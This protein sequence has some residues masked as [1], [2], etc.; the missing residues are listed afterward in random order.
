MAW[1]ETERQSLVATLRST[2]P[3]APTLCTGWDTRHVLAHLVQREHSPASSVGDVVVK[4]PP[5]QE[6]YLGRLVD[7]ATS[8]AG[9]DA[10]VS[11]FQAGPPRWSPLKLAVESISLLEY[12]IHHEDIRRGGPGPGPR[13]A[14]RHDGRDLDEAPRRRAAQLSPVSG[15]GDPGAPRWRCPG[16]QDGDRQRGT[17]P[18]SRSS[19]RSTS[20]AD[21]PRPR[22]R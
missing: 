2:D 3:E 20:A 17:D 9:Y 6:K 10:L 11:R 19:S 4:R 14:R 5:G 16:G 12:V 13:S 7:G 8:P 15:R 22:C 21:A 18:G 1:A